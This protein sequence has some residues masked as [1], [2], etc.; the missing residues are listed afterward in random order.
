MRGYPSH[1]LA[2]ARGVSFGAY[3]VMTY[4]CW[5]GTQR[6]L[7]SRM[8]L[9]VVGQRTNDATQVSPVEVICTTNMA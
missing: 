4:S 2:G 7:Q 9:G 5:Q 6:G 1:T 8:Y 3:G